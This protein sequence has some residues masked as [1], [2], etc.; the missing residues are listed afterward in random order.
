MAAGV[1]DGLAALASDVA[2]ELGA[3]ARLGGL[4]ALLAALATGLADGQLALL[5]FAGAGLVLLGLGATVASFLSA[6]P[7]LVAVSRHKNWVFLIS[8]VLIVTNFLYTYALA[9]RLR[10]RSGACPI[11]TPEGCEAATTMSRVILWISAAIYSVG[12]FTAY[13]LGPLLMRFDE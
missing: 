8:G 3:V 5:L 13:L 12:F 2:V 4:A 6:I 1:T 9:P 7:W 10:T 11:D